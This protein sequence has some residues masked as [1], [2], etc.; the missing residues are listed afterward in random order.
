MAF[1]GV[2]TSESESDRTV[3]VTVTSSQKLS[4]LAALAIFLMAAAL[5]TAQGSGPTLR[6]TKGGKPDVN[7]QLNL[8]F[9]TGPKGTTATGPEGTATIPG[10]IL[11]ANKPHTHMNVYQCPDGT[12]YVVEDGAEDRVPCPEKKRRRLAGF[13]LDDSGLIEINEDAGTTTTNF[14]R[15]PLMTVQVG[16]GV[17]FK[18]F[19]SANNC[20]PVLVVFPS[21]NCSAGDRAAGFDLEATIGFT[22]YF[23]VSGTYDLFFKIKR[24]ATGSTFN[25]TDTFR[26]QFETVMG[27]LILPIGP[28]SIFAEGGGAFSQI[29]LKETQSGGSGG[30]SSL[31]TGHLHTNVT[32]PAAGGGVRVKIAPQVT[33]Q[34]HYQ[35]IPVQN[36][37]L[38]SEHNHVVIFGLLFRLK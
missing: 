29:D 3:E 5:T 32:G 36:G 14:P 7:A 38:L 2:C 20:Q 19:V 9:K 31:L 23:A 15:N 12:L 4:G 8:I 37:Q 18:G 24:T 35:Y 21:A 28:A 30:S 16:G 22:R 6:F 13:Y 33:F 11:S 1:T 34:A 26:P 27:Q 17:G 25:A 10:N